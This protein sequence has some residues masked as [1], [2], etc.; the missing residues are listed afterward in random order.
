MEEI[1][2]PLEDINQQTK[3]N[4]GKESSDTE[5]SDSDAP[6]EDDSLITQDQT[7]R[8]EESTIQVVTQLEVLY[9]LEQS[10]LD[11]NKKINTKTSVLVGKFEGCLRGDPNGD[12][13]RWRLSSYRPAF[14]FGYGYMW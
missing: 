12:E 4:D 1:E 8:A 14:E 2:A 6:L 11:E 13:L 7:I 9:D 3:K 10:F 5:N